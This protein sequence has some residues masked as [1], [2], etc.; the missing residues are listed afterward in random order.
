MQACVST[1]N[2]PNFLNRRQQN[3]LFIRGLI[4]KTWDNGATYINT[5]GLKV[6]AG[7]Q[8]PAR[9]PTFTISG[10]PIRRS[11]H[12]STTANSAMSKAEANQQQE[13]RRGLID[14]FYKAICSNVNSKGDVA[15]IIFY[16]MTRYPEAILFFLKA[17]KPRTLV[18][19]NALDR[20]MNS[21]PSQR[22]HLGNQDN[23]NP[24]IDFSFLADQIWG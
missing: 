2:I 3:L 13:K 10:R 20:S 15:R 9:V 23:R 21:K 14:G 24:F 7:S 22:P 5:F 11:T 8:N 12:R 1:C 16:L 19:W 4:D 6:W 18:E 17:S